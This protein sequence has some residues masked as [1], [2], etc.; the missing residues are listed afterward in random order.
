MSDKLK[1]P[2][3]FLNNGVA[4]IGMVVADLDRTVE[5][6]WSTFHIGPWNFYTYGKPLV[7][8]MSYH[9]LPAEYKMRIALSNF[10]PMRIELIEVLE[11]DTVYADFVRSRGY[12]VQHLGL[13]VDNME[14]S[15]AE[16][17]AAGIE[18][19]MDGSGFGLDGDG[20]YAYLDTKDRF[21]VMIELI[22][23]PKA[24]V[25]PENIYPAE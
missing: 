18:M 17:K 4:Q 1:L 8:K 7:K 23:R 6:Y 3:P 2:L 25:A 12:G 5:A 11:G 14:D 10:G 16:A 21:G 24:R 22:Q 20:H 19:I 15:L 13:L 9:G